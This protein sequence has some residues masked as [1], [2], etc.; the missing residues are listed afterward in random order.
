[1]KKISAYEV[2]LSALSCALATVFLVVGT[3]TPILLFTAYLVSCVALMLPLMKQFYLGYFLAYIGTVLL[4]LLFCGA[5]FFFDLLPFAVFFGLHPLMNELQLKWNMNKWL[6]FLI[7]GLW[8]DGAVYLI[9]LF[10]VEMT[11]AS[12]WIVPYIIPIILVLGTAFFLFYDFTMFRIR[13]RIEKL[14]TRIHKK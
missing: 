5:A 2:A 10:L 7:K 13:A 3:I 1:M 12:A 8:F 11:S 9:W 4:S 6:A 14:L